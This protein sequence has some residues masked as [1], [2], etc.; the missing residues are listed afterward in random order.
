MK[1]STVMVPAH[2]LQLLGFLGTSRCTEALVKPGRLDDST[3]RESMARRGIE[4]ETHAPL[5]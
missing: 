5:R 2:S 3:R 4:T 1:A